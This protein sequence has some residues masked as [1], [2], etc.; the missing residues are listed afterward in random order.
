MEVLA[1]TITVIGDL[2]HD[3]TCGE[4][5]LSGLIAAFPKKKK[6]PD[7]NTILHPSNS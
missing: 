2:N 5:G 6:Q 1:R 3:H 7:K 4:A